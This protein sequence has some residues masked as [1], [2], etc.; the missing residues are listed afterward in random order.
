MF[1]ADIHTSTDDGDDDG[2]IWC[3]TIWLNHECITE[4]S[5][6]GNC[7]CIIIHLLVVVLY[8]CCTI[9]PVRVLYSY[10]SSTCTVPV[11]VSVYRWY[12]HRSP[13]SVPLVDQDHVIGG[14]G[15]CNSRL[16]VPSIHRP[17]TIY[18]TGGPRKQ[19]SVVSVDG[20]AHYRWYR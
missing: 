14:I 12:A 7:C 15:M 16:S 9:V 20:T 4:Y 6:P 18:G 19:L 3:P 8:C 2:A 10:G 1:V 5:G 17:P 11:L 13:V